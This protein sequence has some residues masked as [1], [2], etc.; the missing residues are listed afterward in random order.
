MKVTPLDLPDVLLI[1]PTPHGDARGF[2]LELWQEERYAAAGVVGPF[3]Q[4]NLSRSR[5]HTIRGLHFQEPSPQG[6]LV[7]VISGSVFDVAVDVRQGSPNFGKWV[8]AE[9]N[10][11]NRHQLWIPAGFAHGFCVLSEFADFHYKTT[12]LWSPDHERAVLYND[13]DIGVRWP[14][15][16]PIVSPRD[17]TAPRLKDAPVLPTMGGGTAP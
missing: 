3:V 10:S 15:D 6:K 16:T 5:R 11:E 7:N 4:D 2:F 13:P 1:A 8:G 17:E 9:L 12:A 14:T